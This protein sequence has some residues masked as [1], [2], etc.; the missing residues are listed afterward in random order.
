[1]L[2]YDVP[3]A[4][5]LVTALKLDKLSEQDLSLLLSSLMLADRISVLKALSFKDKHKRC[6]SEEYITRQIYDC[7]YEALQLGLVVNRA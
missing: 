3:K 6:S 5:K 1:M 2:D 7:K 4:K